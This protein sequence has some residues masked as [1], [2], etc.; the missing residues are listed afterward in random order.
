[1]L[2]QD[3]KTLRQTVKETQ[4]YIRRHKQDL[5][6]LK[7]SQIEDYNIDKDKIE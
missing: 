1:M 5:N 7:Q 4:S 3:I 6:G 2:T